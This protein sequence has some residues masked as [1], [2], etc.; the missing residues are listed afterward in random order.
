MNPYTFVL[1]MGLGKIKKNA[2]AFTLKRQTITLIGAMYA[3]FRLHNF[4]SRSSALQF[5]LR[6]LL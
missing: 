4:Q 3:K 5:S 6:D 2:T 1:I